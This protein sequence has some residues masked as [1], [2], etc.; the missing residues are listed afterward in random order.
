MAIFTLLFPRVPLLLALLCSSPQRRL[1]STPS[2]PPSSPLRVPPL[3]SDSSEFCFS[4]LPSLCVLC[5]LCV[6]PLLFPIPI[7]SASLR[8]PLTPLSSVFSSI[9]LRVLRVPSSLHHSRLPIPHSRSC[10]LVTTYHRL[11]AHQSVRL[12]ALFPDFRKK[13]SRAFSPRATPSTALS[14]VF[15]WC[16]VPSA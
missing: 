13:S 10:R 3:S 8:F 15:P 4:P 5:G 16:P 11:G 9:P 14:S 1:C 12:F 6:Q 2:H 7:P